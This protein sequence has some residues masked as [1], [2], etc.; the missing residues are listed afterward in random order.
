MRIRHR[1]E[2]LNKRAMIVWRKDGL[3]FFNI[4]AHISTLST[5]MPHGSVASSSI[6]WKRY[7]IFLVDQVESMYSCSIVYFCILNFLKYFLLF[8]IK[9]CILMARMSA[10]DVVQLVRPNQVYTK[11][12]CTR[13][14][15]SKLIYGVYNRK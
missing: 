10:S 11:S 13:Q 14:Q 9:C 3:E 4:F 7:Q 6:F 15:G 5:F 8:N 2:M 1:I 12:T